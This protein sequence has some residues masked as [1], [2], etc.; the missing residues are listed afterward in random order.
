MNTPQLIAGC[1]VAS[2]R[3]K[4][5]N[6]Q[7]DYQLAFSIEVLCHLGQEIS[8]DLSTVI[9]QDGNTLVAILF[10]QILDVRRL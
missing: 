4:N 2:L 3:K 9:G 8:F 7:S 1:A 6:L 5:R 10:L